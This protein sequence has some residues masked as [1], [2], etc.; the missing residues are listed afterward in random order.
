V[1][2]LNIT[3]LILATVPIGGSLDPRKGAVIASILADQWKLTMMPAKNIGVKLEM[4]PK[5]SALK[6]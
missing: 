6:L 2:A 5:E 3:A 1:S 4:L